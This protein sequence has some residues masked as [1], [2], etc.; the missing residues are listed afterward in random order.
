MT[1]HLWG[2]FYGHMEQCPWKYN[3]H[4]HTKRCGHAEGEDEEYVQAALDVDIKELGF[5]DHVFLPGLTQPGMRGDYELLNDYLASIRS[6]R[7]NYA[8]QMDIYAG[9]EAEYIPE[10]E[11]YY[12]RLLDEGKIDYLILGQHYFFCDNAMHWYIRDT[13]YEAAVRHYTDDVI[14]GMETGLF[15]YV[16]HPDFFLIFGREWNHATIECAFAIAGA[17]KRLGVPLEVNMA[18]GRSSLPDERGAIDYPYGKFW[19][20][21]SQ[22]GS[23]VV[24]GVDAHRPEE[25]RT[26]SYSR[27]ETFAKAHN[28]HIVAP[29]L[30][31]RS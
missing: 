9:F 18:H 16:A 23:D 13:T 28:L 7:K 3:I 10:F 22:V 8:K 30:K 2:I 5:S 29:K 19:D 25:Y 31:H 27:F 14:R 17:S 4:S 15:A 26:T 24:F 11:E 20:I 12:R 1:N 6:L 21:V